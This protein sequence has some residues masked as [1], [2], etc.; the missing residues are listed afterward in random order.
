[1]KLYTEKFIIFCLYAALAIPF[2]FMQQLLHPLVTFKI[3][4]FQSLIEIAFACYLALAVMYA[5]YRPRLSGLFIAVMGLFAV[6][7]LSGFMGVNGL[8]S[9][10]SVPERMTGIFLMLHLIAYFSMLCGMRGR[11][12]WIR[13]FSFSTAVSF[14]VALFPVV[15]LFVPGI[16]FDRVTERLGGTVGN[17][18]FLSAY[19]MFHIF[20]GGWLAARFRAD[21]KGWWWIWGVISFFDLIV[22]FLTQTRGALVAL[23]VAA[24][25]FGFTKSKYNFSQRGLYYGICFWLVLIIFGGIF[26]VT[27]HA[28]FWQSIPVM[29]RLATEGFQA[30]ARLMAWQ[31]SVEAFKERPVFGWGWE[32]FYAA[33]NNHYDPRLLR[34]GFGET[35]FDKPH[36]VFIQFL[37]ETGL[38]GF[39][40]YVTVL[41]M[42]L[43][44]ARKRPWLM[45]LIAAYLTQNF[46]AFDTISSYIMIFA[47]F[48]FIDAGDAV[49]RIE[50]KNTQD[51][52]KGLAIGLLGA[53]IIA[54][55]PLYF[56]NYRVW[57]ASHL[58][59]ISINYFVQHYIPEGMDYFDKALAAK[60]PYHQYIQ[61]D[62]YPN[63]ALFYKQ[64]IALPDVKSL[65]ARAV[66]GMQEAVEQEP[67]NYSFLIGLAD[68]M[69]AIVDLDPRYLDIASQALVRAEMVSPRRQATQYVLAKIRNLKGDKAGAIKAMRAAIDLDPQ[70]GDAHFLYALLLLDNGQ[71]AEG[72]PELDAAFALGRTAKN[73]EEA[74]LVASQ[75]GEASFYK[76]A[77]RYYNIALGF[78]P[79]NNEI[80]MKLGLVYYFDKQYDKARALIK[81]VMKTQDLKKSPQYP[82]IQ[83]ILK[84]LG[85]EQ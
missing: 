70:V 63:I 65:V 54:F 7:A 64:N 25:I 57:R 48:A 1:M 73:I 33:F 82:A 28:V 53:I 59:W 43:W 58:E 30:N 74:N 20:I 5:E 72:L 11:F 60:T 47:V 21:G 46:F 51:I 31:A 38:I 3:V 85:L 50:N 12:S 69:P 61:K 14:I 83:P 26:T 81:E 19:L 56:V 9:I 62:L 37:V 49:S 45:A 80:Q 16:F 27:R 18:I 29:S 44:R 55:I 41:G 84:E 6:I 66:L 17:P 34:Y 52:N 67:L 24:L 8:R 77:E 15:Q 35:F 13:Y 42:A 39:L 2:V 78:E 4:I 76:E 23:F 75:L 71:I 36:N 79:D 40:M 10:W 32:N 68:M 22:I